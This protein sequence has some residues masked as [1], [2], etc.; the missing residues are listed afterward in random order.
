MQPCIFLVNVNESRV[1]LPEFRARVTGIDKFR[2]LIIELAD[3]CDKVLYF[4]H[5][6]WL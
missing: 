4:H 6:S 1:K 5:V 3:V 2:K